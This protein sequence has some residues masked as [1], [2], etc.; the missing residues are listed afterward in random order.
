MP[1]L[2]RERLLAAALLVILAIALVLACHRI[3]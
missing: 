3:K 2:R 1:R